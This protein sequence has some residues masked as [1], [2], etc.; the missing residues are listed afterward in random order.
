RFSVNVGGWSGPSI[1]VL[2]RLYFKRVRAERADRLRRRI[3]RRRRRIIGD[4]GRERRR[5]DRLRILQALPAFGRVEDQ[6]DVAVLDP[7]DDMRAALGD[8]VDALDLDAL[9]R[10][11][12]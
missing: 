6:L 4:V 3:A 1:I 12:V 11:I 8:L 10:Q 9:P 7:V 2:K 5:A